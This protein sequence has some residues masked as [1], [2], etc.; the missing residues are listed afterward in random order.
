MT[1]PNV[2]FQPIV[3]NIQKIVVYETK[4]VSTYPKTVHI[5]EKIVI[6][7]NLF[8]AIHINWFNKHSKSISSFKNRSD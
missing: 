7:L 8:L 2:I 5:V 4:N 6:N 3:S 1:A